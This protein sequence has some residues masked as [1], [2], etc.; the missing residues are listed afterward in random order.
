MFWRYER[1]LQT[2][3]ED[4]GHGNEPGCLRLRSASSKLGMKIG[5]AHDA[6]SGTLGK[7][8]VLERMKPLGRTP[9]GRT[10]F[11]AARIGWARVLARVQMESELGRPAPIFII[12]CGRSGTTLLGKMFDAHPAVR[13]LYEPYHLWAAIEPATDFLQALLAQ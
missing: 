5:I 12:G 11:F 3:S 7:L 6:A 2:E 13:Y 9:L 10:M 8:D 4:A 1:Q